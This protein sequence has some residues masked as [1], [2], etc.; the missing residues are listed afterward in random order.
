VELPQWIGQIV[1]EH[2]LDAIGS[3][4]VHPGEVAYVSDNGLHLLEGV[5]PDEGVLHGPARNVVGVLAHLEQS[6]E[7]VQSPHSVVLR[8]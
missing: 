8:S 6:S 2:L 5:A 7:A 3:G 1:H 4:V